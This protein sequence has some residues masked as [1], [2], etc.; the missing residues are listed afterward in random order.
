MK[1]LSTAKAWRA[2]LTLLLAALFLLPAR[3][4]G[5]AAAPQ[6]INSVPGK[7]VCLTI[8]DGYDRKAIQRDLDVLRAKGVHCT[9][10]VIGDNLKGNAD[11]WRRAVADGH[12][13]CYH[14]MKHKDMSAWSNDRIK[15]DV[16]D[17]NKLA[18]QVL[19]ANYVIP[20]LARLP[21]G[22]G[23]RNKRILQLFTGMGYKLIGW[24]VDTYTG[25]IR[26]HRSIAAY[27]TGN[28]RPGS[29]ILTHFNSQDSSA[30]PGYIDTLRKKYKLVT[31]SSVLFPSKPTPKPTPTP[32]PTPHA[33]G[34]KA[35]PRQPVRF[36]SKPTLA[37][38]PE[39]F[40]HPFS[41]SLL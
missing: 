35:E 38:A 20:R 11:L 25:A 16:D 10:F 22:G 30:L 24:N 39:N 3:A 4:V 32:A 40:F 34:W 33:V 31:V 19:G 8:D 18:H 29:I 26:R 37:I 9:F 2:A 28:T 17:W 6:A 13:V 27:V 15:R 23:H 21:G 5:A 1:H 14:S 12:E 41:P 7:V 36:I